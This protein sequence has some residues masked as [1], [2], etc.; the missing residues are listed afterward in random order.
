MFS[1]GLNECHRVSEMLTSQ[2]L[3]ISSGCWQLPSKCHGK[4]QIRLL[5]FAQEIQEGLSDIFNCQT[6]FM[7][8][9]PAFS[10]FRA[11]KGDE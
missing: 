2:F 7:I 11:D 6:G 3:M 4:Y 5:L 9:D 8:S 1:K 10:D